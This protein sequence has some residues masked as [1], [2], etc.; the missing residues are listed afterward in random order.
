M[1]RRRLPPEGVLLQIYAL[2]PGTSEFIQAND[3]SLLTSKDRKSMFIKL[4]KRYEQTL[5]KH[6]EVKPFHMLMTLFIENG[7]LYSEMMEKVR[8]HSSCRHSREDLEFY[9]PQ[10]CTY[11]VFHEEMH[12]PE[13]INLLERACKLDLHFAHRFYLYLNSLAVVGSSH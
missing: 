2:L 1:L 10:L 3:E 11:L 8:I 13:L 12:S 7:E 5:S 9:V 6:D 4:A